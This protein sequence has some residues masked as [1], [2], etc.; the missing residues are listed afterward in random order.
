MHALYPAQANTD[1]CMY[2]HVRTHTHARTHKQ[3]AA[4]ISAQQFLSGPISLG[5][6]VTAGWAEEFCDAPLQSCQRMNELSV[7]SA[8]SPR[9]ECPSQTS[10]DWGMWWHK[11]DM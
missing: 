3:K 1:M 9:P 10:T 7:Q 6:T 5:S 11:S 8:V 4:S 2:K